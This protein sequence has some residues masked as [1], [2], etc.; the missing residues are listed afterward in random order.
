MEVSKNDRSNSKRKSLSSVSSVNTSAKKKRTSNASTA[1][2]KSSASSKS[3]TAV[4]TKHHYP[5]VAHELSEELTTA[6]KSSTSHH[7]LLNELL[8]GLVTEERSTLN[9]FAQSTQAK[10]IHGKKYIFESL[11]DVLNGLVQE[12]NQNLPQDVSFEPEL[13]KAERAELKALQETQRALQEHSRKLEV[14]EGDVNKLVRDH[15]LW[16]GSQVV[17]EKLASIPKVTSFIFCYVFYFNLRFVH[18]ATFCI[19]FLW[20]KSN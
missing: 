15:D 3:K 11:D 18:V 2:A 7:A 10:A 9:T 4:V 19:M 20:P 8:E 12:V 6:S 17:A 14:Y 13:S 1:S 5:V 16:L